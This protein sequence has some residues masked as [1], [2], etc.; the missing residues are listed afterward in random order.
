MP[1]RAEILKQQL[2]QS[3]GLPWQELLPESKL[4]AILK[5]ENVSYRNC[6]YTL[7]VIP[8]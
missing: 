4:E 8:I 1:N 5:E 6:V 2:M 7:I 3:L